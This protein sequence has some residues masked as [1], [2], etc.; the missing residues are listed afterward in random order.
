MECQ[1][2][3]EKQKKF[4]D[5]F[6]DSGNIPIAMKNAGYGIEEPTAEIFKEPPVKE[7]L[8]KNGYYKSQV[9]LLG[10]DTRKKTLTIKYQKRLTP[11]ELN[12]CNSY[13]IT[14]DIK[15]SALYAGYNISNNYTYIL[16]QKN[17]KRYL[18]AR[19]GEMEEYA[20]I[21][22]EWKI[23]KLKSIID[24]IVGDNQT[25]LDRSCLGAAIAAIKV[26]NEMQGHNAPTS[27]I[28]ANIREDNDVAKIRTL[29]LEYLKEKENAK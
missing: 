17:I 8:I 7:H 6:I 18:N 26:L 5:V 3:T 12:F 19:K 27:T 20:N 16:Q 15:K 10:N 29:T 22:F 14:S 2:L 24:V 25:I 1:I 9:E 11:R 21:T 23:K 13:L 4:C 28:V